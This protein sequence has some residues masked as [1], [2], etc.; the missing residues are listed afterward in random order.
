MTVELIPVIKLGF[1]DRSLALP[2]KYP[3]WD[4]SEIWDRYHEKCQRNAGYKDKLF[5]YLKGSLFYQLTGITDNNLVKMTVDHTQGY[6]DGKYSRK[7]ICA[8]G[9]GY[10][11]QLDGIDKYF[12]QCCGEL[13]D[14]K[15]W[16]NL[17][18][19]KLSY[20]NEHPTPKIH[21]KN[22]LI[23]FD[24]SVEE[25]GEPFQPAPIDVILEI[26]KSELRK[27]V[28]KVMVQL[29]EFELRLEIINKK[30][31]LNL[32]DIGGILIWNNSNF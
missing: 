21:F 5:P 23:V 30:E 15:Y 28:E 22:D 11:L 8:L 20:H 27:A 2:D 17:S 31:K 1:N 29:K 13:S 16:E 24:F 32:S 4:N 19:G 12:P 25:F 9:G 7:E 10:V 6:R 26:A 14:I 18:I 3:Y